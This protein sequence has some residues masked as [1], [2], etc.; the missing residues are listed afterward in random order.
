MFHVVNVLVCCL[1]SLQTH[2]IAC[3]VFSF[4]IR[5]MP[6]LVYRKT[7]PFLFVAC[8]QVRTRGIREG[9]NPMVLYQL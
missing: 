1:V 6:M 5:L 2:A 8:I 7:K 3:L 9:R 4:S